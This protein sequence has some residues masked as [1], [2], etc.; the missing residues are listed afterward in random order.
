MLGHDFLQ[1]EKVAIY[2]RVEM[3]DIEAL[4]RFSDSVAVALDAFHPAAE[5]PLHFEVGVLISAEGLDRLRAAAP[6]TYDKF[7]FG[8]GKVA[9]KVG[10][11]RVKFEV[12]KYS[13]DLIHRS[14]T[15]YQMSQAA[16]EVMR[17]GAAGMVDARYSFPD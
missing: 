9:Q 14:S 15:S 10:A 5:K 4:H 6:A 8:H 17:G 12:V 13:D 1:G 16:A 7:R 3:A 11:K 2:D